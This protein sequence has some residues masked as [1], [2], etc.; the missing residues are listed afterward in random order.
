MQTATPPPHVPA[1][2]TSPPVQVFPVAQGVPLGFTGLEQTPVEGLHVPAV[3]HWSGVAHT[4]GFEPLQAPVWQVSVWVHAF[5]SLH[6]VPFAFAGLVQTPVDVLQVP[7]AW[8]WSDAIHTTG[9]E[10]TQAPVWQVS[11]WVQ[12]FPSLHGDPFAF[13]GLVQTPVAVL[14]VPT[15]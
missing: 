5:P 3:W 8:H 2:H 11:L 12:A 6:G 10:P 15:A 4:T 7:T 13:V 14:Q 9:F 1:V